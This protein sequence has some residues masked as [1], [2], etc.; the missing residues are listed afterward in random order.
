METRQQ[1]RR[2]GVVKPYGNS[3]HS[4][5]YGFSDPNLV[6][7]EPTGLQDLSH[8]NRRRG[9]G[10]ENAPNKPGFLLPIRNGR[11]STSLVE[12]HWIV[13]CRSETDGLGELR[14]PCG[15]KRSKSEPRG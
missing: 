1:R 2:I 11:Q 12:P 14:A 5:H 10:I 8:L 6:L 15:G 13:R 7:S 4:H 3:F 9:T